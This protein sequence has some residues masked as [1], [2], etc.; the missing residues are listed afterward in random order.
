[1]AITE[2]VIKPA[3]P[4]NRHR[5][6]RRHKEHNKLIQVDADVNLKWRKRIMC[7]VRINAFSHS[8]NVIELLLAVTSQ[9][10]GNSVTV[11]QPMLYTQTV[12]AVV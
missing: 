12:A 4:V 1:M 9:H 5:L 3:K 7:D 10:E 2:N 8:R 11:A 6:H